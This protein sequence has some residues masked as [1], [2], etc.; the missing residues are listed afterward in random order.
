VNKRL[1][2][3]A[4]LEQIALVLENEGRFYS[5]YTNIKASPPKDVREEL[6]SQLRYYRSGFDG[7]VATLVMQSAHEWVNDCEILR[8]Y[9]DERYGIQSRPRDSHSASRDITDDALP[10]LFRDSDTDQPHQPP[11]TPK[12][13]TMTTTT[14][15]PIQVTT[16]TLVNGRDVSTMS[17]A[18]VFELI[19]AQ[20]AKIKELEAIESKPKKLTAEIAKRKEGIAALVAHLDA[21]V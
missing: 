11:E 18:E 15:A 6:R 19:A 17:D 16:K 12:E 5:V 9:F 4:Q 14:N 3:L 20:E 13:P 8:R 21:Q 10:K 2:T 1:L 7:D